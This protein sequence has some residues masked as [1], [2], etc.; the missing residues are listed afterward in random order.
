MN[1][2]IAKIL[3]AD[4]ATAY[5][6][7]HCFD[8]K[9]MGFHGDIIQVHPTFKKGMI[10]FLRMKWAFFRSQKLLKQYDR[11]FFSNEAISGIWGLPKTTKSYYYAHSISRH[12]FDLYDDY[13]AKVPSY[14]RIPYRIMA[15]F[16]RILYIRELRKVDTIFVNSRKN[17]ERIR[18]W[19]GRDDAI[20]LTPPVDTQKF[21]PALSKPYQK[22]AQ[23]YFIS[24]ARLTHPKRVHLIIEAFKDL[25]EYPLLILFGEND[26][27]RDEFME[28]VGV[29]YDPQDP[30]RRYTSPRYPHI[31]F[32]QLED[33][34]TLPEYISHAIASIC[35]SKNED[36]GMVA[37]ES[38]ACGTPVIASMEG[39]YQETV[40]ENKT[41]KFVN[42]SDGNLGVE[43]LKH[44]I[45]STP[46]EAWY[47]MKHTS[48]ERAERF[49]L[50]HFRKTLLDSL[51]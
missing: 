26:S 7:P 13:L 16:M 36:F 47:A 37:I 10:G 42:I 5:W 25:P 3:D 35:I 17:K 38:M 43:N 40:E 44:I 34:N 49:S 24:F 31:S 27:Q 11:V 28:L 6:S 18:K 9:S 2:E 39:G 23:S 4:I 29:T 20:I 45:R 19:I 48:R 33:N 50:D 14:A 30:Y 46:I 15:Y 32:L 51:E 41:G 8:A 1:I 12:L 22:I 21:T